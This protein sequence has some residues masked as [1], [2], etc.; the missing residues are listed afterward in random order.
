L[1][2]QTLRV[3]AGIFGSLQ[4]LAT[5]LD[6]RQAK[7]RQKKKKSKKQKGKKTK[8]A[9]NE[10]EYDYSKVEIEGT[11]L[12]L[13]SVEEKYWKLLVCGRQM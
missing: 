6:G 10:D 7:T 1:F 13:R 2:A 5:K 11:W 8:N 3:M 9:Q 4:Q 12:Q